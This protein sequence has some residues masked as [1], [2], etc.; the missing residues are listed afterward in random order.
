MNLRGSVIPLLIQ[1]LQAGKPLT[2]AEPLMTRFLMSLEQSIDLVYHAFFHAA[3]GD[4]FVRKAPAKLTR[5]PVYHMEAGN[6][7]F[8]EYV[9]EG[10]SQHM[11]IHVADFNI[12]RRRISEAVM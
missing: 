12:L 3:P 7:C 11:I 6:R 2:L 5:I 9:P 1:Q 8:C 10:R 4:L